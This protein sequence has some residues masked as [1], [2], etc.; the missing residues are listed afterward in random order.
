MLINEIENCLELLR[1]LEDGKIAI[2]DFIRQLE[3]ALFTEALEGN[4]GPRMIKKLKAIRK[5]K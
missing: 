4:Y 5:G 2:T 1:Q 3:N